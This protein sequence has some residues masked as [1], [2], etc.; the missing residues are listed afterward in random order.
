MRRKNGSGAVR[1]REGRADYSTRDWPNSKFPYNNHTEM[2]PRLLSQW[3]FKGGII[4][5]PGKDISNLAKFS[6][7]NQNTM[8]EQSVCN[9]VQVGENNSTLDKLVMVEYPPGQTVSTWPR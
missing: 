1:L 8:V 4:L 7:A 2:V 5:V 3:P 9:I 6:K